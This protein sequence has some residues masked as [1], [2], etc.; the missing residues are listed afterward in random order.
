IAKA[1]LGLVQE[2]VEVFHV[3]ESSGQPGARGEWTI[4]F[5]YIGRIIGYPLDHI[6]AVITY[7]IHFLGLLTFITMHQTPLEVLWSCR[8]LDVGMP[9]IG[10]GRGSKS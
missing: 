8:R 6:N 2:I 7:T 10:A 3:V 4:E 9:W 5:D 1:C